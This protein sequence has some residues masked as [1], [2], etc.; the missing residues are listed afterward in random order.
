MAVTAAD[1]CRSD[2]MTVG[3]VRADARAAAWRRTVSDLGQSNL[4]H[5]PEWFTVIH[6]TYGH[7]PLYLT[8]EDGEGSAGLLPAF[9]VRRPLFGTVVTSMPFLDTGG[10]CSRSDRVAQLLVERLVYEARRVNAQVIELRCTEKL[11]IGVQPMQ[12]K[13]SMTLTLPSDSDR[14][15]RQLD[16]SVRNQIRKAERAG[17]T[18]EC[19][20][21]DKLPSFY[22]AFSTRMRDL[23]SPVHAPGFLKAAVDAFDDRA[24]VVLIRKGRTTVGGLVGLA[25]KDTLTVPWASCLTE[26]LPMCPNMLLYWE[27]LRAACNE[28]LHAFDFGRSS[29]GSGTY[30][31][32]RQWGAQEKPLFWYTIPVA[33]RRHAPVLDGGKAAAFLATVWQRVPLSVTRLVGP[34]IR[35][36]L[37]Q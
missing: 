16:S 29:R 22:E 4:A 13:V 37:T 31:F 5:S 3:V 25:F 26:Y 18:V 6:N 24:R 35:R 28:G 21:A 17:L 1:S 10:P 19:G 8:A 20:G 11:D 15:W 14:L 2:M 30:R 36:Y 7:E 12:H 33:A 27:T 32:K 9:V 34:S 23:G